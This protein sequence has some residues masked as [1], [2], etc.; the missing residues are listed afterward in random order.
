LASIEAALVLPTG[1][2]HLERVNAALSDRYRVHA[3]IA[4]GGTATVYRGLDLKHDRPVAIKVLHPELGVTLAADRFLREIQ[5]VAQLH[6]PHI[7]ALYDSGKADGLLYYV[8]P[9]AE[10]ET[11]RA[12]IACDEQIPLAEALQITR[13]VADALSYAHEHDVIHCDVKPENVMLESGHAVVTDFGISR[14]ISEA[15]DS[16]VTEPGMA[17]GTPA[18]MSPEQA[19]GST[20]LDQRADVYSLG[21]VLYEM[22][23]GEPPFPATSTQE[24]LAR[25]ATEPAPSLRTAR[26]AVTKP[27]EEALQRALANAPADRF[28][29]AQEFVAGLTAADVRPLRGS[30]GPR[31]R[32]TRAIVWVGVL[33]ATGV[34][35]GL[36]LKGRTGAGELDANV[37][38]VAPFDVIGSG[39]EMWGEGLSD[40]LSHSLDGAGPLRTVSPSLVV[41]AW[42]GPADP[43]S[44]V[45]LGAV[46]GAGLTVYGRL[47]SGGD[48]VRLSTTLLDVAT[49]TAIRDLEVRSHR[50]NV[51][52][53]ADSLAVRLL[54]E[55]NRVR[56]LGAVQLHSLGSS[57]P[58][59][60]KAFLQGEQH[61]RR[62]AMD[63]AGLY[64]ERAIE[65][66]STF[67]LAYN[68]R[69]SVAWWPSVQTVQPTPPWGWWLR[70]GE[71]NRGLAVRES[72]LVAADSMYAA[73][74]TTFAPDSMTWAMLQRL[75][76]TLEDADRIYPDDPEIRHRIAEAE[77]HTPIF[78]R[79]PERPRESFERVV[80][81]DSSFTTAY[82][83]LIELHGWLQEIELA[84]KSS[85]AY[86]ARGPDDAV[87]NAL[88]ILHAIW[89]P[90]R[91]T[92]AEVESLLDTAS[93]KRFWDVSFPLET[94]PDSAEPAIQVV[95]AYLSR[96]DGDGYARDYLARVL[97]FRGHLQEAREIVEEPET[98][99]SRYVFT[100]LALLGVMEPERAAEVFSRFPRELSDLPIPWWASIGDTTS[101]MDARTAFEATS[102]S[103]TLSGTEVGWARWRAAKADFYLAMARRDTTE[104]LRMAS[105]FPEYHVCNQGCYYQRLTKARLLVAAGRVRE[106]ARLLDE[107]SNNAFTVDRPVQLEYRPLRVHVPGDV[108]WRLERARVHESLGNA[109]QA[110]RDYEFVEGVWGNADDSLQPMVE[111]S[112]EALQR[113]RGDVRH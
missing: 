37:L 51:D 44:A 8:M 3:E 80:E 36:L 100:E 107:G 81:L 9:L 87:A 93:L 52:R 22:L 106:A 111:E 27:V 4:W 112:R 65:L 68:R 94:L 77:L 73:V 11:L 61:F 47:V 56:Q 101:I 28:R 20:E 85:A 96:D 29:T 72:L 48:S 34:V 58:V 79:V 102:R 17:I 57:S 83:H 98:Y 33:V 5:I 105:R 2:E 24:I 74:R 75:F 21:C 50:D 1:A 38:A 30:T 60:L 18:Y 90:A 7:L 97:A 53:L 71:L 6:H 67:A 108:I 86:L 25:K 103:D 59:A 95:R 64:Y 41:R 43:T 89:D 104:A 78:G 54:G 39:L 62:A 88:R 110:I 70:A 99:L 26:R 113:L 92:Q 32:S 63:S 12:R 84:R 31:V 82:A 23:A 45:R 15:G 13:E 16:R 14:A 40:M 91:G 35:T 69:G 10:G 42:D 49:Q 109:E 66:D 55:L 76:A 46:L 19:A